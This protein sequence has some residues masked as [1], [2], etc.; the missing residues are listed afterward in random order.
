MIFP[1]IGFSEK[2]EEVQDV[3]A[4]AKRA[5]LDG[6]FLLKRN[7][8]EKAAAKFKLAIEKQPKLAAAHSNYAFALRQVNEEHY[9]ES[10][11]H[12]NIALKLDPRLVEAYQYRGCLHFLMGNPE[13]AK[14]DYERLINAGEKDLAA[15][16]KKFILDK[17]ENPKEGGQ[18]LSY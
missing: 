16:L 15:K 10:L 1:L 13:L 9:A 8:Y 18:V 12:Y 7:S 11:K 6:T 5:F 14:V 17:A 3:E 4:Q 2:I